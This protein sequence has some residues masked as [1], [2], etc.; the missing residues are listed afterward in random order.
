L[1]FLSTDPTFWDDPARAK[2]VLQ[3][4]GSLER[5]V[6][7]FRTL[8]S[9]FEDIE[10]LI[11]MAD[12]EGD[13][14]LLEEATTEMEKLQAE[15]DQV[16]IQ[17]LLSEEADEN[18]AVLEINSGAGGTEAADWASILKRMYIGWGSKNG[19]KMT[20]L[21]ESPHEEAGIKSCTIAFKGLFAYGY[22]KAEIGV[23]RLVRISPFDSNAR[24][25]TS[26]ASIAV[27]PDVDD[28]FEI[29]IVESDLR[30][31]TYRASGAGGQHVNTTDSAVRITHL[32]TNIVV[33]CQAER[34]QHKNKDRAMK[35]LK[36]KLYQHELEKRQAVADAANADKKKIEWGSQIRSY[37][38]HP[39][40][41]IKDLRTGHESSNTDKV[42]AGDLNAY[43]EK[44]LAQRADEEDEENN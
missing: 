14:D 32:P 26:F 39:Y 30:I 27:S 21:E 12:E 18:D 24:R 16:E 44:W 7:S 31:D 42:L 1:N 34:S 41:M 38:L 8:E 17:R 23:H 5:R 40:K 19:Y 20:I 2:S 22:L 33:Q 10:T 15:L 6:N 25:H 3:E 28:D 4:K 29:D 43:M 36:G 11:E 37:V 13:P 35:M 9:L